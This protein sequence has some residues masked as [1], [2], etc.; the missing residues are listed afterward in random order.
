MGWKGLLVEPLPHTHAQC[1]QR[2]PNSRVV[3]AALSRGGASGTADFTVLEDQYGGML[4]YL[5]TTAQHEQVTRWAKRSVVKVPL[6]SLDALLAESPGQ[7]VDLAVI[8]VEGGEMDVL[9]GFDLAKHR[10]RVL[11]IEDNSMGRD[12]S[13][14]NY[15]AARQYIWGGRLAVND[16][17][18]R[19]DDAEIRERMKW[20]QLG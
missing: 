3:Q 13:V 17:Y 4:S 7:Q 9:D 6:T 5:Q 11:I 1:V 19:A 16:I 18:V 8:D 12:M 2:R 20:L 14:R 15:M 10:P